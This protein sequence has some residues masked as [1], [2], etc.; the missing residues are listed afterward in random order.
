MAAPSNPVQ[1]LIGTD[2]YAVLITFLYESVSDRKQRSG[3]AR[4][5]SQGDGEPSAAVRAPRRQRKPAALARYRL[6]RQAEADPAAL[7][8]GGEER[9]EHPACQSRANPRALVLD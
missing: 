6:L 1:E 3:L 2:L 4:D 5:R 8:L 9:P 7:R